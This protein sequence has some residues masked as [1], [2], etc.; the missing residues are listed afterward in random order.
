[1]Q[2]RIKSLHLE[3]FGKHSESVGGKTLDFELGHKTIISGCNRTGKS[4]VKRAIQYILGCKDEN[5]K[6]ISGIRP[7]D[8]NGVDIDG[9]TTVAE[10]TIS[11]DGMENTLK[12]TCFQE[13]NR[14]GE[15][16]GKDNLQYFV[17]DV[18]KGTKKAYEE[19]IGKFF[20]A[21][22]CMSAQEVLSK[23]MAGRRKKF[24]IFSS[25]ST[26]DIISEN[27]KFETLRA[28]LNTNSTDDLKKTCREKI[29][30]KTK[31]RDA[32]PA[33]IEVLNGQKEDIDVAELELLKNSLN[34]QVAENKA[35]QADISKEFEEQQKASDGVIE[36]QMELNGL[37]QKANESLD[38][39]RREIRREIDNL[40]FQMKEVKHQIRL[41]KQG[42]QAVEDSIERN[43][44]Q[45]QIC[46]Q[47][48]STLDSQVKAEQE[49]VFD[50]SSL[51]C[52]Y[53]GQEYP[54]KKKDELQA[55][56]ESHKAEEIKRLKDE[57]VAVTERGNGLKV[58]IDK[59]KSEIEQLKATLKENEDEEINLAESIKGLEKSLEEV[60]LSIDI[61]DRPKVQEI[62]RQIAEK[63]KA[64]NKGNSASEIREN[65]QSRLEDLQSQLMEVNSKLALAQKNVEIDEQIA[66]L[67]KQQLAKSQEIAD[68]ERELDLLKQ[69]ERK[70]AELLESDVNSWFDYVRVKMSEIQQNGEPKD[71]CLITVNGESY[72]RNLNH[73]SKM[74]AEIDICMAFQRKYGI[75]LPII[76][77]DTE[78]LNPWDIPDV[79]NQII[80]LR[81]GES[82]MLKIETEG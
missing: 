29:K 54:A 74:L 27:P 55:E 21:P 17:D 10:M 61:S 31:E 59:N 32:F 1:M 51:I 66:D 19:F 36:L 30:T 52:S 81:W 38:N 43:T 22:E 41:N 9:L 58:A 16:T 4:T 77:D 7:H 23:D 44:T 46:R 5:G 69:F 63:E 49:R 25:H 65:L 37:Q 2:A 18:R 64:M 33:K 12:R 8:D 75:V 82:E 47:K 72:D 28:K 73:G 3:N 15:Y 20:P 80:M 53:C 45:I 50:D 62:Q 35:K 71:V 60:P 34:E 79:E 26:E 76:L 40:D 48:W 42:I 11:V 78:S 6:E 39:K 67:Q 13:K 24:E 57:R 56:F 70:K 14:Q 68:V